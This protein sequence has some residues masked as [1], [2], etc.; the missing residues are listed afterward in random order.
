MKIAVIGAGKWGSALFH[1][2]S[3]KNEC[4]ISSRTPRDIKNFVSLKEALECK[5]LVF[6]IPTQAVA[7]WLEQNFKY[8]G[9]KILVASKG[10][11]TK[12]SRFL[13]EIYQRYVP[14]ENLAFLSGPTFAK[15]VEK[16][17]PCAIVISSVNQ[18]L[19]LEFAGFF[20]SYI[21]A[22][23][24]DDVIGAEICGAYKNVIAIAGGICDGLGLGNNA[25]ASL[26]SR[27]LVEMARFGK[28]FGA[29]DETFLGLSGAG[30]LFLTASS[31]LSRNYRVGIG[32]AK[33]E[34]LEKILN[35]LGEVAE[36]VETARAI[37]KIA[38][39]NDIYTPI[40]CEV[41]KMLDGK[42]V[43]ESVRSLLE[44]R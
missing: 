2:L 8:N 33:N 5:Y 13:N 9:Q 6:T 31:V 28:F 7:Q 43:Y 21:K 40:A 17:L 24:S 25:R 3:E 34:S 44:K 19:A 23:A 32:L 41:V 22:Y 16:K 10:I 30:D 37:L 29:K 11:E 4:V 39:E 12:S 35:E 15:E 1:A 42:D 20:P 14:K 36:G 27:G 26:I 18:N 38:K